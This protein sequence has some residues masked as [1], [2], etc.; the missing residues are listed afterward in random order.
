M[1][2]EILLIVATGLVVTTGLIRVA[3][4]LVV[5]LVVAPGLIGTT[6]LVTAKGLIVATCMAGDG[7]S[8]SCG[9]NTGCIKSAC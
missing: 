1:L 4:D 8:A 7:N 9:N 3:L 2:V 5:M 6:E